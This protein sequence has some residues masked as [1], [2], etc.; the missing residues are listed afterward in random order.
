MN[1]SNFSNVKHRASLYLKTEGISLSI[2][3][4][5]IE[6]FCWL[7]HNVMHGSLLHVTATLPVKCFYVVFYFVII[8]SSAS[9]LKLS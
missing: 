5:F 9:T 3:N 6:A 2:S 7:K 1:I 8:S 4:I